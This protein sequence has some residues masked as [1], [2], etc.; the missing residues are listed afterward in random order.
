MVSQAFIEG[1]T[2]CI[3]MQEHYSTSK[4]REISSREDLP[5]V[6]LAR[7]FRC[8]DKFAGSVLVVEKKLMERELVPRYLTD[9]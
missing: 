8:R 4:A 1:A 3:T 9:P 2:C 6:S 7:G 5:V